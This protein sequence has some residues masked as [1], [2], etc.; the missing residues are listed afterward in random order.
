MGVDETIRILYPVPKGVL[1]GIVAT[2]VPPV[3]EV[4]VP[5]AVGLVKLPAALL[6]C[7]VNIFPAVNVVPHAPN[8][9]F[10]VE[11]THS[12]PV[13]VV[14]IPELTVI[15]IAFDVAGFPNTPGRLDVITHVTI[16]PF[17]NVDVVKVVLFVPAFTPFTFH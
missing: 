16:C 17:V 3:A 11:P 4:R 14:V 12:E 9:T 8:G 1:E 5:I 13:T 15:G 10:I 6:S 7:A 2:M